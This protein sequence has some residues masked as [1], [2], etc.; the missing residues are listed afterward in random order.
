M[1]KQ[2]IGMTENNAKQI[3]EMYLSRYNPT[4]WDGSGKVPSEVIFEICRV[5]VDSMYNGCTLDIQ[6]CKIDSCSGF[7]GDDLEKNGILNY[8]CDYI[9]K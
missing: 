5:A 7:I 1:L 6:L 8:I 9:E 4:Y 3:A 2:S